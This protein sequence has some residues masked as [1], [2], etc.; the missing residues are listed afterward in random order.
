MLEQL[1]GR[2]VVDETGL[3]GVFEVQFSR[4]AK[5]A[6]DLFALLRDEIGLA[7]SEGE[8]AVPRLQVSRR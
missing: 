1:L 5:D 8:R 2:P 6:D 3:G 7:V 4:E